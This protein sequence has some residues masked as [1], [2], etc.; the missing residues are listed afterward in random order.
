[1]NVPIS[2]E[3]PPFYESNNGDVWC[4]TADPSTGEPVVMHQPN[5]KSGGQVSFI[6]VEKFLRESPDGAQHLA[7]RS[8]LG[9]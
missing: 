2:D 4:L 8:L 6:D 3:V 1:M 5:A 7:L 9:L